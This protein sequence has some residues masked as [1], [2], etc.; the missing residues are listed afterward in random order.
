M[1]F[2]ARFFASA[3]ARNTSRIHN[4]SHCYPMFSNGCAG[5][6]GYCTMRDSDVLATCQLTV[7]LSESFSVT[8]SDSV[9]LTLGMSS[10]NSLSLSSTNG[11]ES[12]RNMEVG[13]MR[14]SDAFAAFRRSLRPPWMDDFVQAARKQ[15]RQHVTCNL[16]IVTAARIHT[17]KHAYIYSHTSTYVFRTVR[18]CVLSLSSPRG[19]DGVLT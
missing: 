17:H 16:L 6:R 11:T 13:R 10:T 12:S 3:N 5:K 19:G 1:V 8:M 15:D 2:P 7:E 14:A 9:S 4:H 18:A